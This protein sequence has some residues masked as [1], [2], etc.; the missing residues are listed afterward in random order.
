MPRNFKI[1]MQSQQIDSFLGIV[2]LDQKALLDLAEAL[3]HAKPSLHKSRLVGQLRSRPSLREISNL[4]EITQVLITLAGTVDESEADANETVDAVFDLI[5]EDGVVDLDE[6]K[7]V[8]VKSAVVRMVLSPAL[9]LIRSALDVKQTDERVISD[10]SITAKMTPLF[11]SAS[12]TPQ[13][14]SANLRGALISHQMQIVFDAEGKEKKIS[15]T[16]DSDDLA[17]IFRE[18]SRAISED[19]EL[20]SFLQASKLAVIN[21][22]SVE[23]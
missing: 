23:E 18:V 20:R 6:A 16:L 11:L 3:E 1:E 9:L 2:N 5:R 13:G 8:T 10:V 17:L 15:L 4:E 12:G 21:Q 14:K 19:M 22:V 7:L